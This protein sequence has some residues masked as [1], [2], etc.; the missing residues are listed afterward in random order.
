MTTRKEKNRKED[1]WVKTEENEKTNMFA[2]GGQHPTKV[3][4]PEKERK[5]KTGGMRKARL[6]K[7]EDRAEKPK[8]KVRPETSECGGNASPL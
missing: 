3:R 7:Q 2:G 1:L 5:K 6:F 4:N 8:G